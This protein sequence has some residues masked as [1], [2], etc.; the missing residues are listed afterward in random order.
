MVARR[1]AEGVVAHGVALV[2][3][4]D[5][6]AE[7]HGIGGVGFQRVFQVDGDSTA[8]GLDVGHLDLWGRDNHL[9]LW[10]VQFDIFAEVDGHLPAFHVDALVIGGRTDNAWGRVVIPAAVRTAHAGTGGKDE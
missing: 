5:G 4:A 8:C 1:E 6:I 10:V 9:V 3:V 7:V 2:V